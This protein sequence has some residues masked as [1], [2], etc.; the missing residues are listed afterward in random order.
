M[1]NQLLLDLPYRKLNIQTYVVT[2][3]P[4]V[5]I[6]QNYIVNLFNQF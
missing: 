6:Q 2:H 3:K 5:M 1:I 4:L